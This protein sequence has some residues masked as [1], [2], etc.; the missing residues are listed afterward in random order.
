[1]DDFVE[2]KDSFGAIFYLN[3]K[4]L[5][6]EVRSCCKSCKSQYK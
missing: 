3:L 2:Q 4:T 1:M 6:D 5:K